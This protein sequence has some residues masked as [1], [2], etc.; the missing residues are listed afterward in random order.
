MRYLTNQSNQLKT[1]SVMES[2]RRD[3]YQSRSFPWTQ[4]YHRKWPDLVKIVDCFDDRALQKAGV[5]RI[6]QLASR[7]IRIDEKLRQVDY[8][9]ICLEYWAAREQR[10][11][12]W[13]NSPD[14]QV[15]FIAYGIIP[16]QQVY[17]IPF[18]LLRR[19]WLENGADWVKGYKEIKAVNRGKS[20]NT[21]TTVSVGVPRDVLF[22]ALLRVSV[23]RMD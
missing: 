3:D 9:D 16:S 17:F 8:G 7:E 23:S 13:V 5:D 14:A 12:G 2:L 19:A 6:I 15:D 10:L 21:F 4:V 18:D 20:G 22:Q 1:H 11:P